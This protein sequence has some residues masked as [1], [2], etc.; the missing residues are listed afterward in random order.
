MKFKITPSLNDGKND[1]PP[2]EFEVDDIDGLLE[3]IA[4][5]LTNDYDQPFGP[6]FTLLIERTA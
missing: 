4:T 2:I 1:P 5:E 3:E 6:G